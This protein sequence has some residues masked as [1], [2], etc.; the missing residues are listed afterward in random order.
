MELCRGEMP[1]VPRQLAIVELAG[2]ALAITAD[3][4]TQQMLRSQFY[5]GQRVSGQT[6]NTDGRTRRIF[7]AYQI[8]TPGYWRFEALQIS[9]RMRIGFRTASIGMNHRGQRVKQRTAS[10]IRFISRM[11]PR[12]S[13]T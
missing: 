3:Q 5:V 2:F 7:M 9:R 12:K 13:V 8:R 6:G 1:R 4:C 10:S 11:P